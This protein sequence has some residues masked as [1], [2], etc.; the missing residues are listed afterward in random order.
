MGPMSGT[1]TTSAGAIVAV[2]VIVAVLAGMG[3]LY[4][5]AAGARTG[6]AFEH[7]VR[8]VNRFGHV[9]GSSLL[10]GMAITGV[11]WAV[12]THTTHPGVLAVVLGVPGL[13]AGVSVARAVTVSTYQ[14]SG[15]HG[16]GSRRHRRAM[17]RAVRR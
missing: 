3:L 11:Q 8:Q 4:I 15:P 10:C 2:V 6:R 9:L 1:E 7:Q 12:V 16:R 14:Y 5:W 17:R 13:V